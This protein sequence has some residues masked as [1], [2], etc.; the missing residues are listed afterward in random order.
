MTEP[1]IAYA[2]CRGASQEVESSALASVYRFVL[3]TRGCVIEKSDPYDTILRNTK[4]VTH[5]DQRP[6]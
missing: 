3:K 2:V 4:E 6:G 5:V 1:R